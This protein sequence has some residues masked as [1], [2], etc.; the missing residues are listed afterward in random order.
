MERPAAKAAG[1]LRCSRPDS[2]PTPPRRCPSR[3]RD[4]EVAEN[5]EV[6]S[7][8]CL[9]LADFRN[10]RFLP[11]SRALECRLAFGLICLKTRTTRIKTH[12]GVFIAVGFSQRS[13][14]IPASRTLGQISAK[15]GEWELQPLTVS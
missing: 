1:L 5:R 6:T 8:F 2:V 11:G 15:A 13:S 10:M 12:C 4:T 7:C 14:A 9:C 3:E